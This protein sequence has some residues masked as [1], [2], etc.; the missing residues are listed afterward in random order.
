MQSSH[1]LGR[2]ILSE[3]PSAWALL[4]A[5]PF[6]VFLYTHFCAGSS[7]HCPVHNVLLALLPPRPTLTSCLSL[8]PLFSSFLPPLRFANMVLFKDTSFYSPPCSST[9]PMGSKEAHISLCSLYVFH[10][11]CYLV[12]CL[13]S[14]MQVE[15]VHSSKRSA[16]CS[17]TSN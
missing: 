16:N 14:A 11:S 8:V 6:I 5:L 9:P 13:S 2:D 4:A 12:S 15:T 10:S 3:Q 7:V 1:L 17:I